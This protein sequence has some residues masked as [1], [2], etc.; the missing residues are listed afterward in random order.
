VVTEYTQADME[1][2]LYLSTAAVSVAWSVYIYL[3]WSDRAG[4]PEGAGGRILLIIFPSAYFLLIA[5]SGWGRA[6][7]LRL[8][9]LGLLVL[10]GLTV[11]CWL[12]L[13]ICAWVK[14][15]GYRRAF[16]WVLTVYHAL[17]VLLVAGVH[18]T[19]L[20]PPL[21]IVLTN[22]IDQA[23]E[24]ELLRFTWVQID[25]ESRDRD[26]VSMLNKILIALFS[27]VP[28]SI[29]RALY[30]NRQVNR[31]RKELKAEIATLRR[32]VKKL[33]ENLNKPKAD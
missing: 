1:T 2:I 25:P 17:A 33:E 18:L 29:L 19:K 13:A 5:L 23:G 9:I 8:D 10:D 26:L 27:Y 15:A 28:I 24:I 32:K 21:L 11:L 7:A 16:T 14:L 30:V 4:R 31:Q 20:Y 6:V 22:L 12:V 3:V